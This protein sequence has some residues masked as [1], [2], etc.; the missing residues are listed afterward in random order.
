MDRMVRKYT[1][2]RMT[3]RWPVALFYNMIDVSAVNG[4]IVWLEL[5]GESP[6]ISVKKRRNFL[7][8][9][10]KELAGVNT[11]PEPSQRVSVSSASAQKRKT[12]ILQS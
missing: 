9:L 3:R 4:F 10:G 2:K 11:Q 6:S 8:E 1:C 7:L 12:K 5:N